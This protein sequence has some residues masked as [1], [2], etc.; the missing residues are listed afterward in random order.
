MVAREKS[1][2]ISCRLPQ[3]LCRTFTCRVRQGGIGVNLTLIWRLKPQLHKHAPAY[4]GLKSVD[5]SLVR[6]GGLGFYSREFIRF[7]LKLTPMS[8]DTLLRLIQLHSPHPPISPPPH[9]LCIN[10]NDYIT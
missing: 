8:R 4:A 5:F 3:N 2:A 9:H 10:G 6:A 1:E 7:C